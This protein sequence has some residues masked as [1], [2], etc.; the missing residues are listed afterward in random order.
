MS[1]RTSDQTDQPASQDF[2]EFPT[3]D[4]RLNEPASSLN[5]NQRAAIRM[6]VMGK[7]LSSIAEAIGVTRRTLYNWREDPDFQQELQRRR[8]ELWSDAAERLRAMVHSSLDIFQEHLSDPYDRARFR[9]ANAVL[10]ISD[11][12]RVVPPTTPSPR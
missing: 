8:E 1:N 5:D 10:R 2:P 9:A 7:T 12:R 3:P 6:I 4:D 11:L